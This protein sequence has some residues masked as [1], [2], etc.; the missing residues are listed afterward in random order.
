M[1]AAYDVNLPAFRPQL[2]G[3]E[4]VLVDTRALLLDAHE[5]LLTLTGAGGCGKTCLALQ[6]AAD[7]R[8]AFADGVYLVELASISDEALILPTIAAALGMRD[9]P[10]QQ[11]M[12]ALVAF[13]Q[14]RAMLLMLDNCEHLVDA[15]AR[16]VSALLTACPNLRILATSREPLQIAG[17]RQRRIAPLAV[18]ELEQGA[19]VETLL[20]IP[21][22]Q[23]FVERAQ[24]VE[25]AFAL[26]DDNAAAVGAICVQLD[27]IPLAI[28]LAA[29]RVRVLTAEQIL[30]RM[31]DWFQLLASTQRSAPTRQQTLKATLDWS[32][33]LLTD[34]ERQLFRQL[35]VFTGGWPLE[36]AEVFGAEQGLTSA[37]TL[38]VL[39]R[40]I[41]KSLV[42]V[43]DS[44]TAARYWMLEPLR[45][46]ALHQVIHAGEEARARATHA[47]VYLGLVEQAAPELHGVQQLDWLVR[48]D[49]ELGNLRLALPWMAEHD[50]EA[51]LR[52]TV[53][54][55]LFWETRSHLREGRHWLELAARSAADAAPLRTRALIGAGRLAH[56]QTDYDAAEALHAES[57]SISRALGDRRG[58]AAALSEIGKTARNRDPDYRRSV[59]LLEESLA[60][61]AE[62]DDREMSAYTLLNLGIGMWGVDEF[63]RADELMQQ[64]LRFY[65]EGGNLRMAAI[66]QTM[67]GQVAWSAERLEDAASHYAAAL[68][69]HHR[70]G[71]WWF[72]VYSLRGLAA[73]LLGQGYIQEATRL[74]GAAEHLGELLGEVQTPIGGLVWGTLPEQVR[75]RLEDDVFGRCWAEGLAL[76]HDGAVRAAVDVVTTSTAA[77]RPRVAPRVEAD[78]DT[79]TRREREIALLLAR[80]K[81][82]RQISEELYIAVSTVGVH[83]H[84]ILEKLGLRSRFQVGD[85]V[86]ASGLEPP[87]PPDVTDGASSR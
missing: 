49:R 75:A 60:L 54:L 3:R 7:V 47:Y 61:C 65:Q 82:D 25:P 31:D 74:L 64:S 24:A 71:D 81:S 77:A 72:V 85:W 15:C 58:I 68:E 39:T 33:D 30:D 57:L 62:L 41:D 27:G 73:V 66:N 52:A 14:P 29:A 34:D 45:Q 26:T 23:L 13:L 70:T 22:V 84:H 46:Y 55:A 48:L 4:R 8:P 40:L 21:A 32:Y 69:N 59:A 78:P 56:Q 10:E 2:I 50:A 67:L 20:S 11:L 12:S 36:A 87:Q 5:R 53:A 43:D 9:A 1:S 79:L 44:G 35:G 28:E 83:V 80:G 6:L 16:H 19:N 86:A 63:A 51:L 18:P 42:Q 38:D 37:D 17:E 76:G